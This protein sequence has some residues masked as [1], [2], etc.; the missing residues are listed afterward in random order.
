MT[1]EHD[2][3]QI[4]GESSKMG[5][6]FNV[7]SLSERMFLTDFQRIPVPPGSFALR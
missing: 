4:F 2:Y 3:E 6:D 7:G 5:N 1:D